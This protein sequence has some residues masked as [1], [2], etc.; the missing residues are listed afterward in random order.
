MNLHWNM[1][2]LW[3]QFKFIISI[4]SHDKEYKNCTIICFKNIIK[5]LNHGQLYSSTSKNQKNL[6]QFDGITTPYEI[7][8][9]KIWFIFRCLIMIINVSNIT[10][11]QL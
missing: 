10:N 3:K 9:A 11:L 7:F 4:F 6:Y 1:Q 2:I 5:R 8:N